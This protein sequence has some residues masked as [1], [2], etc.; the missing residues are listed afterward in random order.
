MF[1]IVVYKSSDKLYSNTVL[2]EYA[3]PLRHQIEFINQKGTWTWLSSNKGTK[4][5]WQFYFFIISLGHVYNA[6]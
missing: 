1:N 5:F 6:R 4:E 3:I 2:Y